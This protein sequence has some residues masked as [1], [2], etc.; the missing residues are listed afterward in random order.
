MGNADDHRIHQERISRL[1]VDQGFQG[2]IRMYSTFHSFLN[3]VI[4]ERDH[5]FDNI[6]SEGAG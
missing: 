2:S 6:C 4:K 5:R 3:L 1:S